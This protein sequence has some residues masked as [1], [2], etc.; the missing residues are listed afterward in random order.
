MTSR[1]VACALLVLVVLL[2]PLSGVEACGPDFEPDVFVRASH[3]DDMNAFARGHLGILQTGFD[4]NE[5][6]V[7]YRYL[8]G[9]KVSEVEAPSVEPPLPGKVMNAEEW[10]ANQQVENEAQPPAAWGQARA[11]YV[12]PIEKAAQEQFFPKDYAGNIVFDPNYLN[13]PDPAFQSA[14]LTLKK[15]ADLWGNQ[16]PWLAD[17]IHGQDAV[18]ANCAGKNPTVPVPAPEK[19]PALLRADRAYQNAS[20]AFYARQYDLAAQ[21]FEAVAHDASSPW[22]GWGGYLA[23]R[24]VVRKAFAMGKTTDPYGGDVASFDLE[25]MRRAQ[26]ML[27]GLLAQPKPMPSRRIVANELNFVRLR[28]E[29]EKRLTEICAAL[30]GPAADDQFEQDRKDLDYI[31]SKHIEIKDPPPLYEWIAAFRGTSKEAPYLIWLRTRALPWLV[32]AL[33]KSEPDD[34]HVPELLAEAAKIKPESPAYETVFYH[35]VRL[36]IGSYR[37]DE[38]RA[39]LDKA[40]PGLRKEPPGS[41]LNALLSERLAV[42]RNF[43]EF[44]EFAP[45]KVLETTA[46]SMADI[47]AGCNDVQPGSQKLYFC[48]KEGDPPRLDQAEEFDE[49]S[50]KVLNRQ[51]PLDLLAN[52]ATSTKLPPNLR[53]A[54]ALAAWTRSVVLEDSKSA[55][56]LAPLLPNPLRQMAGTGVGFGAN[57]AILRNPGLRPY[58][59]P[60]LSR[61]VNFNDLD[62]FRDNWWCNAWEGEHSADKTQALEL[63]AP[64]F[65]TKV[66]FVAGSEQY[67]KAHEIES[68]EALIG[69]RIVEYAKDHPSDPEVPEALWLVVRATHYGC[70]DWRNSGPTGTTAN[71]TTEVSKAAFQLLHKRYPK[72]PWTLKTPYYY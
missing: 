21:Q 2:S 44:L 6:A 38:A 65:L 15:R 72:S 5:Y 26:Q 57:V 29:P 62:V 70:Q 4:S 3:P 23:A 9:G 22:S 16:S 20:A 10:K 30:A 60:G 51:I 39:L 8:N 7:A 58:L 24:A 50:V 25:T 14:V 13:C 33:V 63:P 42:A 1:R 68:S 47:A 45:R 71:P 11:K 59:E 34:A 55:A 48:P 66:E 46:A 31:L 37:Q 28:T 53:R 32:A 43:D 19:A 27:E 67:R 69:S 64:G 12:P 36:L 54:V 41:T 52:A 40:L 49:D 17:W 56:R 61:L 35:R 18:F